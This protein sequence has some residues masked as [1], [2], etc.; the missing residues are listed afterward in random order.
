MAPPWR[1]S[2][3]YPWRSPWRGYGADRAMSTRTVPAPALPRP[4]VPTPYYGSFDVE[5]GKGKLIKLPQPVANLFVADPGYR[6]RASGQPH[7]MFVFGKKAGETDIVGT[8]QNGNRIAQF[9]V[10]VDPSS[11]TDDRLQGQAQN[12]APGSNVTV[13]TEA[14]GTILHGNVDTAAQADL[15]V[16]QAKAITGGTVTNDLTVNEPVQVS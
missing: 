16:N 8:D 3:L 13:E 10:S 2:S 7:S 9:T 14:N 5:V 4:A 15:L 11:Y 1:W 6:H 12:T